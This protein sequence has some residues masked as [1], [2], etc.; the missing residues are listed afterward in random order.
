MHLDGEL[1]THYQPLSAME[2]T[3]EQSYETGQPSTAA[4][5]DCIRDNA[6]N[7][8]DA[9][10]SANARGISVSLRQSFNND[11][12]APLFEIVYSF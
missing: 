5:M 2:P 12:S 8:S 3:N 9:I 1:Q 4:L 6:V 7:L 11:P 10:R